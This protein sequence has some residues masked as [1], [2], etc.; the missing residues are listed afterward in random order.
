M[1]RCDDCPVP[2]AAECRGETLRVKC[3]DDRYRA[4]FLEVAEGRRELPVPPEDLLANAEACPHFAPM[5][6]GRKSSCGCQHM[7]TANLGPRR[8]KGGV[9]LTDCWACPE[10]PRRLQGG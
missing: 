4:Y 8:R 9:L 7:C 5:P 10:A 2:D 3:A 6:E 1:S